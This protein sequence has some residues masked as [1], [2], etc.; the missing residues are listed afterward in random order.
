MMNTVLRWIAFVG[1]AAVVLP[2]AATGA[3]EENGASE[4]GRLG[5]YVLEELNR[6]GIPP[7]LDGI[8]TAE[9]WERKR[10]AIREIW[11]AEM[12]GLP[13]RVPVEFSV[14][15][16]VDEGGHVRRHLR[17]KTVHGD[18]VTASLLLPKAVLQENG[19]RWPAV[20][21]LH[22]T[23]AEGK[24]SV[25][26]KDGRKNRTYG[27]ELAERGYVVLAP[28]AM[29]SGERIFEGLKS[30]R[31]KPFYEK[32]PEWS[33]VGKNIADHLQAVDLLVSLD[34]VDSE[35]IG[36]IGH[37]FGGYNAYFLSSV[38]D[39]IRAVV[40]SCGVSP[41]TGENARPEHW[42][43]RNWYTHLPGI[44][45]QLER[46]VVPFE[47][48]EIIALT[49]PRPFFN[50][51]TQSDHIFPHWEPVGQCMADLYGLYQWMK[52]PEHFQSILG[53]GDHDFPPGIR[54][55][56]YRF[57]DRWLKDEGAE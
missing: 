57:L 18:E 12:G 38:D 2:L 56:A 47:F 37:S 15:E 6:S 41:F 16:E 42:G 43:V 45:P 23:N 44:T 8:E 21:A 31:D 11:L 24:D 32:H 48:H 50:Y 13:E 35:R 5:A 14:G 36:V 51:S 3:E 17:F 22:P 29:T 25:A 46:G 20:L 19:K 49:A 34:Y 40:S 30:F 26:R 28:D 10:E 54:E 55:L 9:D 53:S 7:L 52:A 27:Y 39:R 1:L 4:R 33:T